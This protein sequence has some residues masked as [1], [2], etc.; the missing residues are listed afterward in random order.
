MKFSDLE[1]IALEGGGGK[2]AVYKGAI[3][4]LEKLFDQG[5]HKGD[6]FKIVNGEL[7]KPEPADSTIPAGL[8]NAME[9]TS[10]LDYY[11]EKDV[12]KIKGIAGA[13]AGAITAFPLALGLT[14]DHI[15]AI[16]MYP[17]SDEFLP[18]HKL[19]EGKYRMVGMDED[20]KAK[21]LV[22]EDHF[23]KL[24]ED[25]IA[26]YLIPLFGGDAIGSNFIKSNV[27][28]YVVAA[29]FSV[30]FTGLKEQWAPISKL[31]RI[32]S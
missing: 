29:G 12:L 5:W 16:L 4:A 24:G 9:G 7:A 23:R 22:A 17:F 32:V 3:V 6:F 11:K 27:R 14:S 20:G 21:I 18:N 19:N 30:I 1:N 13:S 28:S 2:G 26:P 8:S 10:I 25:N 31:A 15:D